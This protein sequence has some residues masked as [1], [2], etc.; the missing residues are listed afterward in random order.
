VTAQSGFI[1]FREVTRLSGLLEEVRATHD[2]IGQR[3]VNEVVCGVAQLTPSYEYFCW[4]CTAPAARL[5]WEIKHRPE[6]LLARIDAAL[7]AL[8]TVKS[9]VPK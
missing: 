4:H 2:L 6:C 5:S 7:A 3:P 1:S 9:E 8:P